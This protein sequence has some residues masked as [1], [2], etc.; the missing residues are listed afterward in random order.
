MDTPG[1]NPQHLRQRLAAVFVM[2]PALPLRARLRR[3][4]VPRC[5]CRE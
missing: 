3:D 5:M 2:L 1:R 4:E